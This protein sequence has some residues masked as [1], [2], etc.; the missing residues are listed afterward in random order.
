[1]QLGDGVEHL[2]EMGIRLADMIAG[3]WGGVVYVFVTRNTKPTEA[4]GCVI[5]GAATAN[6]LSEYVSSLSGGAIKPGASGF[7]TGLIAMALCQGIIAGARRW[8]GPS[9]QG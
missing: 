3:F 2:V 1:M 8:K 4:V 5:V 6:Y 7:V 9:F